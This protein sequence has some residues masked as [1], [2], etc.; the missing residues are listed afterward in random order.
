M[1]RATGLRSDEAQPVGQ[2]YRPDPVAQAQ[3]HQDPAHV[4]LD[5]RRSCCPAAACRAAGQPDSLN[6]DGA[7][8]NSGVSLAGEDACVRQ[9]GTRSPPR[10]RWRGPCPAEPYQ[11]G[12]LPGFPGTAGRPP[13]PVTRSR[14]RFPGS[15]HVPGVSPGWCPFPTV[16][17][18]LRLSGAPRKSLRAIIFFF[19]LSTEISTK[20]AWLSASSSGYPHFIHNSSTGYPT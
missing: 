13:V 6:N 15:S 14:R 16:K 11:V 8:A 17:V 18:F 19:S 4:G 2:D 7:S 12:R 20:S 3:L 9:N 5:R 10:M 1:T